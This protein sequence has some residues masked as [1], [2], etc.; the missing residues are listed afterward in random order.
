VYEI[1]R[2]GVMQAAKLMAVLHQIVTAVIAVPIGVI[3]MAVGGLRDP[4][5]GLLFGVMAFAMPL[6]YA[7]AGFAFTA[8]ACWVYNV[9]AARL[10]G[11]TIELDLARPP[12]APRPADP[13]P[14]AP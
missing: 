8:A 6:I 14:A 13:S 12:A 3:G 2:V 5:Y 9:L 10:G 11:L 4:A 7:A 1:K